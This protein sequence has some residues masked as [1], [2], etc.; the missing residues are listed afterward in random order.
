MK[1]KAKSI[2][3]H[4]ADWFIYSH[5]FSEACTT[6]PLIHGRRKRLHMEE[7][8]VY[9]GFLVEAFLVF[10]GLVGEQPRQRVRDDILFS[11]DVFNH[12]IELAQIQRSTNET[13]VLHVRRAVFKV[14]LFGDAERRVM[15][16]IDHHCRCVV[17]HAMRFL[18]GPDQGRNFQFGRP[19][20]SARSKGYVRDD[21][22]RSR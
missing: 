7:V 6:G 1:N 20:L 10:V 19:G 15:V 4:L 13:Q 11:G 2:Q 3:P 16:R 22:Y 21:N 17:N 14:C 18:H 5:N 12:Q 9:I 8:F